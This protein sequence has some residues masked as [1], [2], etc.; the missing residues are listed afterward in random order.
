MINGDPILKDLD[1]P[2]SEQT[3]RFYGHLRCP[4]CCNV[5]TEAAKLATPG[6][7]ASV[8]SVTVEGFEGN[9]SACSQYAISHA[10]FLIILLRL[11]WIFVCV[12]YLKAFRSRVRSYLAADPVHASSDRALTVQIDDFSP[13]VHISDAQLFE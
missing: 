1:P 9:P 10:S 5:V 11:T 6:W 3:A 4:L 12:G 13:L 2:Y 8:S 7:F